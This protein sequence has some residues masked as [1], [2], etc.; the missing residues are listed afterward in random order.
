M[1]CG[2]VADFAQVAP[3]FVSEGHHSIIL[4]TDENVNGFWGAAVKSFFGNINYRQIVVPAGE[5][6]KSLHQ[7]EK[8]W[9]QMIQWNCGR[10]TLLIN[11]GGGMICDLGGF[12]AATYMRGIDFVN[13]PT[14]LLAMVDSAI[15]GKTGL[16]FRGVKNL[17]GSITAPQMVIAWPGFLKTLPAEEYQSGL[18]ELIK[19]GLI[20]GGELWQQMLESDISQEKLPDELV[21]T[22]ISTKSKIIDKDL[23]EQGLRKILNLGHTFGHAIESES[24]QTENPFRHGEAIALGLF[25]EAGLA[26][27]KT[28]FSPDSFNQ[29]KRILLQSKIKLP[30]TGF[31][32]DQLLQWMK[33]DKKNKAHTISFA[34]LE[35]IGQVD[36]NIS[37]GIDELRSWYESFCISENEF[38][39]KLKRQ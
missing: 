1:V 34:L 18:A 17:I 36:F 28:G 14:S 4:L 25:F 3:S 30:E 29:L 39:R 8:I 10:D 38:L 32:F 21:A 27:S 20:A 24:H 13:I 35:K 2:T 26:M 9:D 37:C 5:G 31:T 11:L 33:H 6:S 16:N 12:V 15:G 22:S 23:H 7:A 19:H